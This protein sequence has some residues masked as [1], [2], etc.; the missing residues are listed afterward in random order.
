MVAEF[1]RRARTDRVPAG[2]V[3]SG[4][5]SVSDGQAAGADDKVTRA[6][7]RLLATA[8]RW[9]RNGDRFVVTATNDARKEA[10]TPSQNQRSLAR[11]NGGLG[12]SGGRVLAIVRTSSAEAGNVVAPRR[13]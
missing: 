11:P 2:Q 6:N 1:N 8:R 7:K 5:L 3:S 13:M 12:V 4:G 9:V 10:G